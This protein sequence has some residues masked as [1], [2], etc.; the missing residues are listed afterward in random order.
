MTNTN[1]GDQSHKRI[2]PAHL[3]PHSHSN[4][5]LALI[6]LSPPATPAS[7]HSSSAS[8]TPA[9]YPSLTAL[10]TSPP[11]SHPP[12]RCVP[13]SLFDEIHGCINIQVAMSHQK[14]SC[15]F[16]ALRFYPEQAGQPASYGFSL[17]LM[18]PPLAPDDIFPPK[19]EQRSHVRIATPKSHR[20]AFNGS[21]QLL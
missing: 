12:L 7:V 11:P 8:S 19:V 21:S 20:M 13:L 1:C 3:L 2:H 6:P 10:N 18:A 14:P 15:G 5:T 17:L 16:S 4:L 9:P